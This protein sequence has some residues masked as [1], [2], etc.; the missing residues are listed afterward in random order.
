MQRLAVHHDAVTPCED[1][2]S[3][4][5]C[6]HILF[7]EGGEETIQILWMCVNT[8][9]LPHCAK[10]V[11]P[12]LSRAKVLHII[13]SAAEFPISVGLGINV[14]NDY[15]VPGYSLKASIDRSGIACLLKVL[16]RAGVFPLQAKNIRHILAEALQA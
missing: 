9:I 10:E 15:K 13:I 2:A 14:I 11:L 1:T 6:Q 8:G 16:L 3:F 7:R 12:F 5:F 4:N